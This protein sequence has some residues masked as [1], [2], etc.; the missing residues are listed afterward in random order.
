MA[1][2]KLRIPRIQ[3]SIMIQQPLAAEVELLL[4]DPKTETTKLGARSKLIESLL[5]DWVDSQRKQSQ[6][7]ENSDDQA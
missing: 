3:W 1:R 2:P 6:S 5:R 4:Y 7:E